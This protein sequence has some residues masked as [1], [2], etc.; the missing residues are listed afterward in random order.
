VIAHGGVPGAIAES[1][2]ALAV[3]ALFVAVT[4]VYLFLRGQGFDD[5]SVRTLAFSSWI[6]GH[7]TLA[8]I[9]RSDTEMLLELGPFRNRIIDVW[10]LAAAVFLLVGIYT[11]AIARAIDLFPVRPA[12]LASVAL[13]TVA[14]MFL[15]ELR[16]P[17]LR[18]RDTT[19]GSAPARTS[20]IWACA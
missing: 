5:A 8:F 18:P 19:V 13:F 14:V 3:L 12:W 1:Q 11:P 6:V 20:L 17:L 2:L 10:A 7:V 16:K 15:L 9:S 4:G